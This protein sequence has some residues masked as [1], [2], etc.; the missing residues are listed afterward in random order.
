VTGIDAMKPVSRIVF[1]YVMKSSLGATAISVWPEARTASIAGAIR[2]SNSSF[3]KK[4]AMPAA[5]AQPP[6]T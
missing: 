5:S 4:L 2:I 1:R 3:G 6:I